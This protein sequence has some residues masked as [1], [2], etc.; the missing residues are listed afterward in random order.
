MT[1]TAN[2][3]AEKALQVAYDLFSNHD[4]PPHHDTIQEEVWL[5][6]NKVL[7][8]NEASRRVLFSMMDYCTVFHALENNDLY[9]SSATHS[10]NKIF[11]NN[12]TLNPDL[13]E[14]LVE[15]AKLL[16]V[17]FDEARHQ[18]RLK[19]EMDLIRATEEVGDDIEQLQNLLA[20]INKKLSK[21]DL[22]YLA[23]A[24][25]TISCDYVLQNIKTQEKRSM[26]FNSEK[27]DA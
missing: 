24:S 16:K 12:G 7:A 2:T 15:K 6:H 19:M 11:L 13:P 22:V 1:T 4:Q 14:M 9:S 20:S 8:H 10:Y 23:E 18:N 25:N 5:K 21:Y 27:T 26:R 17:R 3:K